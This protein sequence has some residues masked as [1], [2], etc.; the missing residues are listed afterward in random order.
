MSGARIARPDGLVRRKA[1]N[2]PPVEN[3][4]AEGVAPSEHTGQRQ[5]PA[6][7][8]HGDDQVVADPGGIDR[9][10]G[11]QRQTQSNQNSVPFGARSSAA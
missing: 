6:M 3:V 5:H 7:T 8:D 2:Q 11:G 9:R 1:N 10:S 4:T